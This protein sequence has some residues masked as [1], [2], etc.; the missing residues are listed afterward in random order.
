PLSNRRYKLAAYNGDWKGA[1]YQIS[2]ASLKAMALEYGGGG[3]SIFG[4]SESQL[5]T[6]QQFQIGLSTTY[7]TYNAYKSGNYALAF[8]SL[9]KGAADIAAMEFQIK[10][11]DGKPILDKDNQPILG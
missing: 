11:Q 6:L 7:N 4:F 2:M 3:G 5:Q 10:D 9:A 1:L 8:V